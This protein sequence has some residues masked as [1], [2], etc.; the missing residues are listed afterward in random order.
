MAT[1]RLTRLRENE[2]RST[3]RSVLEKFYVSSPADIDVESIAWHEGNL[4]V[5]V[6][7]L[8]SS[9][10]RLIATHQG[11]IIRV[12]SNRNLGRFRFTVAHELGHYFLHPRNIHDKD[13]SKADLTVWNDATE[14]AEANVFA[15]E[16]LMPK[17]LFEPHC[18]GAPSIAKLQ[19]IA[20]DFAT[21]L[22]ATA[23][24]Y[25]QYTREP[26]AIILSNG[27]K[28]KRF[29]PFRDEG[30]P[31]IR[32][33]KLSPDSAAGERLAK[34]DRDSHR[35]VRVP[36]YA[37]LEGFDNRSDVDIWEDSLYLEYYDMTLTLL[38]M[39]DSLDDE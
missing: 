9:E 22:T 37:W 35:M 19:S 32:I 3:A 33:G 21:S 4:R 34:R 23:F 6:G 20:D 15:A 38:W 14:E 39:D 26:V 17:L 7:G 31:R 30:S 24:Q 2:C 29:L 36:A 16:F 8:N 28:M 10:G 1:N 27:W 12:A 13:I 18:R 11:G 25:Y 5:R